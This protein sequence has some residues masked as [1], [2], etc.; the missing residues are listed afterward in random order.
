MK[1]STSK[2]TSVIALI[3]V[4]LYP[5]LGVL[6][7]GWEVFPIMVLFWSE[8]VIIGF[9]N[10]LKMLTVQPEEKES[11]FFKFFLIP[12]FILHYGGF[13]AGHGIFVVVVFGQ[14]VFE[15]TAGP[16]LDILWQVVQD[17][18]PYRPLTRH[19]VGVVKR[20]NHG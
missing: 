16:R 18:Q 8:N 20:V 7:W 3:V 14:F 15:N 19:N 12:F 13:T 5:V 9:F 11:I 17:F 2:P 10:V 4:N 1:K 6:F